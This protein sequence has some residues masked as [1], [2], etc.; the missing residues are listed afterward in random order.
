MDSLNASRA[1]RIRS[2]SARRR[3]G[4]APH[5][6]V[7]YAQPGRSLGDGS[8][9]LWHLYA[10]VAARVL[11]LPP[12]GC[13]GKAKRSAPTSNACG[14][15]GARVDEPGEALER[16]FAALELPSALL[17]NTREGKLY[18]SP[19]LCLGRLPGTDFVVGFVSASI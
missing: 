14:R 16:L 5:R 19:Q 8:S 10:K 11:A 4:R 7:A 1:C 6:E 13:P 9:S 18:C 2:C 17:L 12:N 3:A 15:S